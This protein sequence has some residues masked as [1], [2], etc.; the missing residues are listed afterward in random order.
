MHTKGHIFPKSGHSFSIF[1]KGLGSPYPPPPTPQ[2][3]LLPVL[4][5][6]KKILYDTTNGQTK[7]QSS[8]TSGKTSTTSRET[9]TTVD[10]RASTMRDQTSFASTTSDKLVKLFTIK[11][12]VAL[13]EEL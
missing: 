12:N 5:V 4:Q 1:K 2:Q 10:K 9:S 6:E 3:I 13:Q 11:Q 8:T 7:G